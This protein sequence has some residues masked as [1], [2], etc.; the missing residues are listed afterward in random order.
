M[1]E[2]INQLEQRAMQFQAKGKD[3]DA[4][5]EYLKILKLDPNSRRIN[6]S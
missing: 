1:S 5:K 2:D 4:L 6:D 3:D